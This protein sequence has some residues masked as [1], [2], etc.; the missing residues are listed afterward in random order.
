MTTEPLLS[1]RAVVVA[2]I[3]ATYNVD[4]TPDAATDAILVEN[5]DYKID[6]NM[7]ERN[8]A[9]YD[10]D[11]LP[12]TPGRKMASMTFSHEWRSN[13]RTNS[14]LIA[15]APNLGK[16][17]RACGFAEAAISSGAGQ[18]GAV[19][20]DEGNTNDPSWAAGGSWSDLSMPI[21]YEIE[22]TTAGAS[23]SA[24][25]KI[26]PDAKAIA[27]SVAAQQTGVTVTSASALQLKTGGGKSTV[28]PTFSGNLALGDKWYVIVYPVGIQYLPV[29]SGF[30]SLTI[31]MYFDGVLHK[32]TGARGTFRVNGEGGNYAKAEF[33]FTGQYI[34]PTDDT[35]P[36]TVRYERQK[37]AMVEL[38]DL[39]LGSI[40]AVCSKFDFDIGVTVS[41]R[42]DV[43]SPD[44]YNGV[45][46]TGRDVKGN[47]DPEATLTAD[48]PWWTKLASGET[49]LWRTKVGQ[50][51]GNRI[52]MI[53]PCV[54]ISN[55]SY[56][57][58]EQIRTMDTP[59]KV[60]RWFGN[61]SI[62]FLIS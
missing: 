47:I 6:M 57:D 34:E 14:G 33:T 18:V 52:F 44:G 42:Q 48:Y 24:K 50:E 3:E 43:N 55:L 1:R 16:L 21:V 17:L 61:D 49:L 28:I 15:D 26:T 40:G 53:A 4:E 10:L 59:L 30:E 51:A 2:A 31:Y 11:G 54:Q 22:C 7:L 60:N 9:R 25:V 62:Q 45:R 41:P 12:S 13:G 27:A 56:Q 32:M 37:P 38:S 46:I 8:N 36:T 35:L 39:Y 29:S 20:A 58:R 23:G 5:P 19:N